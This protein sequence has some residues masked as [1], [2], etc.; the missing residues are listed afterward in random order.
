M[1]ALWPLVSL[2]FA[3]AGTALL[4]PWIARCLS[5]VG[6]KSADEGCGESSAAGGLQPA[7]GSDVVPGGFD[8]IFHGIVWLMLQPV[9]VF[10]L[11]LAVSS[12]PLGIR[13]AWFWLVL[14]IPPCLGVLYSWRKLNSVVS[15]S[16]DR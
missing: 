8:G 4:L 10:L 14:M 3:A 6:R 1:S 12:R 13:A 7:G 15:H 9:L 2:M 11:L 5:D 16:D